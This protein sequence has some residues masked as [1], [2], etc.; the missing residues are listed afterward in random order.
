[1]RFR[2]L[3]I[4]VLCAF[5]VCALGQDGS[6]NQQTLNQAAAVALSVG[7]PVQFD[8][9]RP[10]TEYYVSAE[11]QSET[12][13]EIPLRR[14]PLPSAPAG[15]E[16]PDE[17]LQTGYSGYT[18]SGGIS[19]DGA[20]YN[21]F[22]P[23]D[24][25]IAVGPSYILEGTNVLFTVYNKSG[26]FVANIN[27]WSGFGGPCQTNQGGDI[28]VQ[29]DRA[30]DRWL[31][32][33]LANNG[34]PTYY[35]CISVSTT[36]SP[37]GSYYR[38]A[39]TF[40]SLADYPKVAVWPTGYFASFNMFSGGV[41]F[42]GPPGL[43]LQSHPNAGGQCQHHGDLLPVEHVL[44]QPAAL[45]PGW[46][47]GAARQLPQLLS[48]RLW[49]HKLPEVMEVHSELRESSG[50]HLHR[51]HQHFG[52]VVFGAVWNVRSAIRNNYKT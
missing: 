46:R 39:Y 49:E 45:R 7:K 43:R 3:L 8:V 40:A 20:T 38:W 18:L 9:S 6:I 14:P 33:Q 48:L 25:N 28:I 2:D 19:F 47:H 4:A 11:P 29:Y 52:G 35:F 13:V 15:P 12:P 51:S 17:V 5:A 50:F 42:T 1:M 37:T 41:T 22:Y 10:M 31:V 21:G 30:A 26:A 44:C 23:P 32:T 36:N 16:Q 34:G 24:P 27:P